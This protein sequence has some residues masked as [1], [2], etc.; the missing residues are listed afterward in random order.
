M[1]KE[2]VYRNQNGKEI[3]I[4]E[5][6]K[7]VCVGKGPEMKCVKTLDEADQMMATAGYT[8][9]GFVDE[10]GAT[11]HALSRGEIEMLYRKLDNFISDCTVQE[12][13]RYKD[14][15]IGVKTLL[16]QRMQE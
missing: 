13:E 11:R 9:K 15:L 5:F 14:A 10:Q 2:H 6:A 4:T 12:C 8:R 7:F 1:A 16:H 3:I